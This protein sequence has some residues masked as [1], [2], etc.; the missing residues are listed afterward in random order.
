MEDPNLIFGSAAPSPTHPSG[1]LSVSVHSIV[2]IRMLDD[3]KGSF[4]ARDD[5][6]AGQT[7]AAEETEAQESSTAPSSYVKIALK[8]VTVSKYCLNEANVVLSDSW[9]YQ[10]RVKAYGKLTVQCS[11]DFADMKHFTRIK[12]SL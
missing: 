2:D 7:Y 12:S 1:V 8:S 11:Y 9:I 4:G 6:E 5:F 10:T 3:H